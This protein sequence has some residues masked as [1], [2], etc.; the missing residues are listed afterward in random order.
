M[1]LTFIDRINLTHVLTEIKPTT[2]L[3]SMLLT[4]LINKLSLDSEEIEEIESND[5]VNINL[6]KKELDLLD[7]Q[8]KNKQD[9]SDELYQTILKL[10]N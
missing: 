3:E 9:I 4:N 7:S 6:T 5:S 8:I 2:I 10:W 1:D